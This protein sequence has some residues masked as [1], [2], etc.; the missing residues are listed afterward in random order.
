MASAREAAEAEFRR[1]DA[2]GD[3]LLTADE[4]RKANEALGGQGASESD[5]EAFIA[6]ADSD[7]DGTVA[8]EEFVGLVGHGR[9]E[10]A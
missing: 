4:I 5:V 6:A 10:K 3:G 1:F 8:L 9:H 7:G 2:D